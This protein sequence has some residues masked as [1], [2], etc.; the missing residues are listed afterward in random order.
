VVFLGPL[1]ES[2]RKKFDRVLELFL[3]II[4]DSQQDFFRAL[5]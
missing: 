3:S 4:L 2:S 5:L 1:A